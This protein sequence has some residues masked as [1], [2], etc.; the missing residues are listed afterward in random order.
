MLSKLWR[1]RELAHFWP[2]F[3]SELSTVSDIEAQLDRVLSL[4]RAARVSYC[5]IE[6]W[7][8]FRP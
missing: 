3:V 5:S 7:A 2:A 8:A 1:L 4:L 6:R